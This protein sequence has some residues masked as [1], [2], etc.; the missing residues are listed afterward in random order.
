MSVA[1]PVAFGVGYAVFS[2][3]YDTSNYTNTD[4]GGYIMLAGLVT[5][6]VGV[7]SLITGSS[8]VRK[9]TEIMEAKKVSI[10]L[11]P[12]NFYNQPAQNIQPGIALKMKF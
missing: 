1:G 9:I 8:R 11:A 5:T 3:N 12:Y 4:I 10:E 6:A 2:T 7:P